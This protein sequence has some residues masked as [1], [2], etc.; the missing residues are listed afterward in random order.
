MASLGTEYTS[1]VLQHANDDDNSTMEGRPAFVTIPN[2][3]EKARLSHSLSK[4]LFSMGRPLSPTKPRTTTKSTFV[5]IWI[6]SLKVSSF[7]NAL[8]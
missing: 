4:T 1:T 5:R 2:S 6:G 7:K 3:Q 8:A